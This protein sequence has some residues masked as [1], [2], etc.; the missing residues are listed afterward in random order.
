MLG[1]AAYTHKTTA[2]SWSSGE[3]SEGDPDEATVYGSLQPLNR[4]EL[5]ALPEGLRSRARFKFY[6]ESDLGES[7]P[8][9]LPDTITVGSYDFEVHGLDDFTELGTHGLQHN[10]YVLLKPRRD[11]PG[12]FGG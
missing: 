12:G 1:V 5:E 7:R 11:P 6:T 2:F 3:I 10:M 8:G 4:S 9:Y